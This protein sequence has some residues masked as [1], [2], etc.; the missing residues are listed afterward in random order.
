MTLKSLS[1]LLLKLGNQLTKDA[2]F[3]L[4]KSFSRSKISQ[5]FSLKNIKLGDQLLVMKFL[6]KNYVKT[7]LLV[8]LKDHFLSVAKVVYRIWCGTWNSNLKRTLVLTLLKPSSTVAW[9]RELQVHPLG[10]VVSAS[11]FSFENLDWVIALLNGHPAK[12]YN[13][14]YS[15]L[16]NRRSLLNNSR[17]NFHIVILI[18]FYINLGIA[19]IFLFFLSTFSKKNLIYK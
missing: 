2:N 3:I 1:Y 6:E 7:T 16:S 4:S 8:R 9:Q 13:I 12:C 19:V 15:R 11:G 14:N 17:L 18:H 10:V 5:N